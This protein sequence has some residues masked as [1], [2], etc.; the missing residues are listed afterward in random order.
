IDEILESAR[1]IGEKGIRFLGF[2]SSGTDGKELKEWATMLLPKM[3]D[4]VI[5]L[6]GDNNG[7]GQFVCAVSEEAQKKGY[8]AGKIVKKFARMAGG[9]GGGKGNLAMAGFKDLDII[10]QL[11]NEGEKTLENL[12]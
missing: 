3:E 5:L 8:H 12:E 6:A 9:D 1:I 11:L 7:K 2:Q 10:P 4:G